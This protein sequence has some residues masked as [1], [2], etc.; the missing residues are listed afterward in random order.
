M[1]TRVNKD[2]AV[3]SILILL[4]LLIA[5]YISNMKGGN[6]ASY[7]AENK[8][9]LG[10]SIFYETLKELRYPVQRI[11]EPIEEK[12]PYNIQ[13]VLS[14][15]G[16][17]VNSKKVKDWVARGGTLI[18][19]TEGSVNNIEYGKISGTDKGIII[20]NYEDGKVISGDVRNVANKAIIKDKNYAYELLRIMDDNTYENIYFN[21]AYL[22]TAA[23]QKGLW[24]YLSTENKF[25][26]YQLLI[27]ITAFFIYKGR[28]FGKPIALYEEEERDGS[29]Y[30]YSASALY[31]H[32]KCWDLILQNYY[33]SFLRKM[34]S[35]HDEWLELWEKQ[36]LNSL[37]KAIYVFDFMHRTGGKIRVKEYIKALTAI[38][39]LM[40]ILNRRRDSYWKTLKKPM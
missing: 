9:K 26:V 36:Q 7:S 12:D 40:D 20:S 5:F 19:L 23:M 2:V 38:E 35:G 39:N 18:Y 25:I 15:E 8:A 3:F 31:R 10:C 21:E 13:L 16:F 33:N 34:P 30:L 14:G 11:T 4:F 1:K 24:E 28:R 6:K 22:E 27:V 37:D 29:E 17:D 32:A